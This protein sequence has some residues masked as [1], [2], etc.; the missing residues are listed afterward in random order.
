MNTTPDPMDPFIWIPEPYRSLIR[1][2]NPED[3]YVLGE[4]R[5]TGEV[6][7]MKRLKE[8]ESATKLHGTQAAIANNKDFDS[9]TLSG[10]AI[11]AF[12]LELAR[13]NGHNVMASSFDIRRAK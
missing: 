6:V 2:I 7:V 9:R 10:G 12:I 11:R 3:V 8:G 4:L 13:A 1:E 5:G